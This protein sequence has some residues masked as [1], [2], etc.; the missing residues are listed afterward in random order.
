MLRT[1][2]FRSRRCSWTGTKCEKLTSL[3]DSVNSFGLGAL[4][5]S[6]FSSF[7]LDFPTSWSPKLRAPWNTLP[8]IHGYVYKDRTSSE[9]FGCTA[10]AACSRSRTLTSSLCLATPLRG[11]HYNVQLRRFIMNTLG[12]VAAYSRTS[13]KSSKNHGC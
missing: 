3:Q 4:K 5:M 1:C 7:Q 11:R 10:T 2:N 13:Y 9:R 8:N 6:G 12:D